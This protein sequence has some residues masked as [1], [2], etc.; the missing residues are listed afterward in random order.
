VAELQRQAREQ[1]ARGNYGE[2]HRLF[3]QANDYA[4]QSQQGQQEWEKFQSQ[5]KSGAEQVRT[6]TRA[7]IEMDAARQIAGTRRNLEQQ[8]RRQGFG[9]EAGA[10]AG[11]GVLAA[12]T[13]IGSLAAQ[14]TANFDADF[15]KILQAQQAGFLQNEFSFFHELQAMRFRGNIEADLM[16]QKAKLEAD[17]SRWSSWTSALGTLGQALGSFLPSGK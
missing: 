2:A 10:L 13:A 16:I 9:A 6:D 15:S 7:A 4:T 3:Q 14:A 5:L 11:G 17:Q 8:Y 12:E 1:Q